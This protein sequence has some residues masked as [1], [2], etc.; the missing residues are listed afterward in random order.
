MIGGGGP[1]TSDE[2]GAAVRA[3]LG[4]RAVVESWTVADLGRGRGDATTS[5]G[6]ARVSGTARIHDRS[7]PWSLIRKV[8]VPPDPVAGVDMGRDVDHWNYWRR[9]PELFASDVLAGLPAGVSAPTAYRIR[10]GG[11]AVTVWMDDVG[12]PSPAPWTP[13]G[14]AAVARGLGLLSGAFAGRSPSEPWLSRDLLGQWVRDLPGM[15]AP[16]RKPVGW[17]HDIARSV[18][19]SG[20]T[21]PVP[22]LLDSATH[23]AA[24]LHRGPRTFCHRDTGLDNLMLRTDAGGQSLVLFD[25]A[26]AGVGAVGEDLGVFFASAARQVAADPIRVC[27]DLVDPYLEGVQDGGGDAPDPDDAWRVATVTAALRESIFAAFHISRGIEV[28]GRPGP[29]LT[30][31]AR[32]SAVIEAFASVVLS[33]GV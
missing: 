26:L 1:V 10:D 25:W 20:A 24:R 7:V 13:T 8:Y 18:F 4:D 32:D 21:G 2:V 9:E 14:L 22:R 27:R 23:H 17:R 3:R 19:A 30:G 11:S 33:D 12:S 6:T 15:A 29:I 5:L 16:L 28:A 31:L